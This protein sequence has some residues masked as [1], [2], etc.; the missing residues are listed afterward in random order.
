MALLFHSSGDS[1]E[2][3]KAALLA[4]EPG[5]D[6]RIFPE[7]G[8][9]A[10]IE[11]ALGWAFPPGALAAL[12]N[13]KCLCS[14]GAGVDHVF[15]DSTLPKGLPV[16]RLVDDAMADDMGDWVA[17]NVLRFHRRDP[18]YRRFQTE[19]RWVRLDQ[20]YAKDRRVGI[21]GIGFLGQAVARR[22]SAFGFPLA[23]WSRRPKRVPG[24]E[25][26]HGPEQLDAFLART[27]ILAILVPATP[28]TENLMDARRLAR[29]PKGAAIVNAAR[30]RIIVDEALLAALDSGHISVA[31]LDVFRE[32]PL[33]SEH[34]YWCHPKVLVF[35]HIAAYTDPETAAAQVV[36]NLRRARA[37]APLQNLV[38]MQA[39]Y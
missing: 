6:F 27:D 38:D 3:W 34:P 9:P 7:T 12:P 35:P 8:N 5:L 18:E 11:F 37:G 19:R 31:A 23:G 24:V 36:D 2:A 17:L 22:L 14:L 13:L 10:E 20:P 33:P 15:R 29:L 26:F 30:G 32:E 21:L 28:A 16:V 25:S 1:P 4:L 39:G